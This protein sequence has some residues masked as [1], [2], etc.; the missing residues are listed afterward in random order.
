MAPRT[1]QPAAVASPARRRVSVVASATK[2][3]P[4]ASTRDA[5]QP[6]RK[7][8][9]APEGRYITASTGFHVVAVPDRSGDRHW[10]GD[11]LDFRATFQASPLERMT[12]IRHGIPA[13]AIQAVA[14]RFDVSQEV[15]MDWLGISRSTL[16]RK[17]QGGGKLTAEQSERLVSL[18]KLAGQVETIVAR[19]GDPEAAGDFDAAAWLE[20]WLS[21]PNPALGNALPATYLDTHEGRDVLSRLIAQMETGAYA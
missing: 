9:A 21:H 3:A 13:T 14:K 8:D 10:A 5:A 7:R 18:A 4:P 17:K 11:V 2:S 15:F 16:G 6:E 20:D 1:D 12:A 19:S